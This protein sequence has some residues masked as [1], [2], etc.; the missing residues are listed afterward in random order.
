[1]R[2]SVRHSLWPEDTS[3]AP[4]ATFLD[5]FDD[6]SVAEIVDRYGLLRIPPN[7]VAQSPWF[8]CVDALGYEVLKV[9]DAKEAQRVWRQCRLQNRGKVV[10]MPPWEGDWT[11]E[12]ERKLLSQFGMTPSE[13]QQ[14]LHD[15]TPRPATP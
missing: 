10:V 7:G 2:H 15:S 6:D 11:E 12:M 4:S 9:V 5:A 13:L 8:Q 1:M 3:P 14:L